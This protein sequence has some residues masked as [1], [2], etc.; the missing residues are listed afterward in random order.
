MEVVVDRPRLVVVLVA[1]DDVELLEAQGRG[2][3]L[4]L[5]LADLDADPGVAPGRACTAGATTR[6]TADWRA[7]T[8]TTPSSRPA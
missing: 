6:T 5:G 3:L 2:R 1:D 4:D 8:R 7:A